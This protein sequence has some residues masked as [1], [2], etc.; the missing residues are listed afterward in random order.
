M[1]QLFVR[2]KV[3]QYVIFGLFLLFLASFTLQTR[4]VLFFPETHIGGSFIF[5]NA[6]FVYLS[7][8]VLAILL[9][10]WLFSLYS[11]EFPV[12]Q[13]KNG[14]F[15]SILFIFT[16]VSLASLLVSR[17]TNI[18]IEFTGLGKLLLSIGL[19]CFI[20]N[21]FRVKHWFSVTFWL[22][23]AISTFQ[24][25]LGTYHYF[26]QRS[27]GLKILGE[28]VFRSYFQGIAKFQVKHGELWI[29]D[30]FMDVSRG[31]YDIVRPYGTFSHP[32]VLGAFL[33][34]SVILTSYLLLV[35]RG[36]WKR[37][38]LNI[39]LAAQIYG[40]I[41]SFSRVAILSMLLSLA[42][43]LGFSLYSFTRNKSMAK[44]VSRGTGDLALDPSASHETRGSQVESSASY[45]TNFFSRFKKLLLTIFVSG[46][47]CALLFYP[48]FLERG[49]VVSHGTTNSK[50]VSERVLY[51][52]T[53]IAMIRQHPLLGVGYHNFVE[54]MDEYAPQKLA[55]YQHQPVHN[56]Y[57]LIAA[58]TGVLGLLVFLCFIFYIL[59][60]AWQG[61]E[62][63][64]TTALAAA[65]VGI[66]FIGL[67]DHYPW[68]IQQGR[69]MF[70]LLA[71][72]VVAASRSKFQE[73]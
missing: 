33:S 56:V 66:L 62:S 19:F 55:A 34:V 35:S 59:Y 45:E 69:L 48:Q 25:I 63:L 2:E 9:L 70:F 8:L 14:L 42:M 17:E 41:L 37:T 64:L 12:K 3:E 52:Q 72:L 24:V 11:R 27:F 73:A 39:I 18:I 43:L 46:A 7:D 22:I 21:K 26:A 47:V 44:D 30:R 51:A 15:Y 32:N 4:K 28:E 1:K 10:V 5:Y 6:V 31:T 68:T 57:L 58:E 20:I 29:I 61:R 54:A 16:G 38:V 36:T 40:V 13:G 65:F 49:G 60:V 67:F 53:A 71:G 23:L 50:S